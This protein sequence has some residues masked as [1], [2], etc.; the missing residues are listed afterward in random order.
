IGQDIKWKPTV[1]GFQFLENWDDKNIVKVTIPQLKNMPSGLSKDF[2][3]SV[4]FYKGAA[5]QLQDLWEDLD[6]SGVLKL[7]HTWDGSTTYYTQTGQSPR[8][9]SHALGLAF[10]INTSYK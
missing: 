1:S 2:D 4:P 7:V 6:R 3:G 8:P 10:D 5:K 9:S